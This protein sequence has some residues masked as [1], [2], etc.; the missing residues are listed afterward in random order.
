MTLMGRADTPLFGRSSKIN[1]ALTTA[2][3]AKW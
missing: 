2:K 3:I 1:I